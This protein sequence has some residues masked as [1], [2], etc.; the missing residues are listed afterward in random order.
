[1]C[2]RDRLQMGI[3]VV[4]DVVRF[5]Q[6]AKG[7]DLI[8]SG[9]GKLDSQ[10]LRGKAVIGVARRAKKLG[11]P[12]IAVV[13]DIGDHIEGVY[14]E[15]VSYTHLLDSVKDW[16]LSVERG[17]PKAPLDIGAEEETQ[18]GR[19]NSARKTAKTFCNMNRP[20]FCQGVGRFPDGWENIAFWQRA[21]HY[22]L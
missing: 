8:F 19:K 1:M 20:S 11:I 4:L 7:A 9:E 13:G 5:E 2:I 17:P 3:D 6:L 16:E 12:L 10:S 14:D 21:S 18:P 15:A 22:P